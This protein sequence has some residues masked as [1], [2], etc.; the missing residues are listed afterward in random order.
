MSRQEESHLQTRGYL[1]ILELAS[2]ISSKGKLT[3]APSEIPAVSLH[4]H[5]LEGWEPRLGGGALLQNDALAMQCVLGKT[6]RR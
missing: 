2:L 6:W 3:L 5:C 1:E 4:V